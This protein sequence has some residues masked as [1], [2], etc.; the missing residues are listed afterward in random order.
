MTH[1]PVNSS[2]IAT[3]GY[4]KGLKL[5]EVKLHSGD[6]YKYFGVPAHI[7]Y[8]FFYASSCGRYFNDV[9]KNYR[10]E[11]KSKGGDEEEEFFIFTGRLKS[12]ELN[13]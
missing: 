4:D 11:C 10:C 8:E 7:Y 2:A 1:K 9:I 3:I 5:L 12:K 13:S 6:V